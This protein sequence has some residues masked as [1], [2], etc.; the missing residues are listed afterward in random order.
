MSATFRMPMTALLLCAT[1]ASP[2]LAGE[3]SFT[4]ANVEYEG[5]KAFLPSTL[6]V[7]KGDQ[8]TIKIL[9]N[10][11]SDPNQHGFS[12]PDFDT[13]T[14][15]TRGESQEVTFTADKVGIFPLECHLHPAHLGGQLIVLDPASE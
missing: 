1:L 12:L 13:E 4:I 9:N 15:V 6:V 5:T 10:I 8:V 7:A 3:R 14:V 2:A 11:P